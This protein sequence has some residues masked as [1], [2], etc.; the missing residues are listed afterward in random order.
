MTKKKIFLENFI[1]IMIIGA[2]VQIFLEDF[3]RI[4]SWNVSA[5]TMLVIIGFFF[6]L[7]FTIEFITRSILSKKEKGWGNY[8]KS[9]KGWVDLISS[10]PLL[11]LNSGPIMLGMIWPGCM[12][13]IPFLGVLNILKITKILR[14]TRVLRVLRILRL[15]KIFRGSEKT[16]DE[17]KNVQLGR[18]ISIVVVTITVILIISPLFPNMFY[19]MNKNVNLKKQKYITVLQE[20]YTAVKKRDIEKVRYLN[21][22]MK[23]DKDILYLFFMG[24]EAV[25]HLGEGSKPGKAI[26]KKY[27]YT[28]YKVINYPNATF[29]KLWYSIEDVI[30]NNARVNLMI[31]TIIIALIIALLKFYK[32]D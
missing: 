21:Q 18:I 6:D 4:G 9:E 22:I 31:E 32:R 28:D 20:W 15:V 19:T 13:A 5:K 10:V 24:R 1:V 3:S 11:L 8:F 12:I 17:T 2:I 25:N 27:F 16:E 14:V 23:D 7:I 26:P 30:K 29:F